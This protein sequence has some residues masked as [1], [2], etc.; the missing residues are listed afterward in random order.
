MVH[1]CLCNAGN[2]L[3]K[4]VAAIGL[5]CLI[6]TLKVVLAGCAATVLF[7]Y[8]VV[9]DESFE[10][11]FHFVEVVLGGLRFVFPLCHLFFVKMV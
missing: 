11:S 6:C 8:F 1:C 3:A 9:P 2:V 5:D 4:F 10:V 7:V